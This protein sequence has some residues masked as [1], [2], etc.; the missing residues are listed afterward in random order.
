MVPSSQGQSQHPLVGIH[1]ARSDIW[2]MG[3][4]GLS[5]RPTGGVKSVGRCG[6]SLC[7]LLCSD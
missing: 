5:E 4:A 7:S 1:K 3:R 6:L 2:E